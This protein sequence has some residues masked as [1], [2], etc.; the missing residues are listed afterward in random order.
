[1][2]ITVTPIQDAIKLLLKGELTS[3]ERAEG[4]STEYPLAGFELKS[5]GLTDGV[6]TLT[7]ADPQGK[8]GGGSCRVGI[9]WMQI[10]ATAKQFPEVSSV[11]FSPEWLFQP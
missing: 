10:E 2:P 3:A 4:I 8:T 9:L 11:R 1:M 5:A 7:F 6:L